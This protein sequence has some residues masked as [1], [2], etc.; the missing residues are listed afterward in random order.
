MIRK[1]A[2][3]SYVGEGYNRVVIKAISRSSYGIQELRAHISAQACSRYVLPVLNFDIT[4]DTVRLYLPF[5]DCKQL[6]MCCRNI[7]SYLRYLCQALRDIHCAGIVHGDVKPSN[8]LVGRG[9]DQYFL[10]DFGLSSCNTTAIVTP[11]S[12]DT[13]K[14]FL[15]PCSAPGT[16]GFRAPELVVDPLAKPSC[17]SDMWAVGITLLCLLRRRIVQM[18]GD[19][20]QQKRY[21]EADWVS[22]LIGTDCWKSL[23]NGTPWATM[24][25]KAQYHAPTLQKHWR[26]IAYGRGNDKSL[27]LL[28]RLLQLEPRNRITA[29]ECLNHPFLHT[30]S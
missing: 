24:D 17:A 16:A 13:R 21:S 6:R 12:S 18:E 4:R 26:F 10:A 28:S 19:D 20:K 14:R 2:T 1:N 9:R 5:I 25:L 15:G 30:A 3:I 29:A 27:D 11:A 7:K 8:F 22:Q 23:S